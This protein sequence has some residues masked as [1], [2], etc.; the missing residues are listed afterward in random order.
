ME[1]FPLELEMDLAT[2][3][4]W[5]GCFCDFLWAI[6]QFD[7]YE[8]YADV[9]WIIMWII[10]FHFNVCCA[11]P[12]PEGIPTGTIIAGFTTA[13]GYSYEFAFQIE[14]QQAQGRVSVWE[15]LNCSTFCCPT[16]RC[17]CWE[18]GTWIQSKNIL[19]H[20]K[21][22]QWIGRLNL[23]PSVWWK[24]SVLFVLLIALLATGEQ[25]LRYRDDFEPASWLKSWSLKQ[26]LRF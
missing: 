25:S 18:K 11:G 8:V 14:A 26:H 1:A 17:V 6:Q 13:Q 20:L 10:L 19:Y 2:C 15:P 7:V 16:A 23:N 5:L 22:G 21:R 3:L 4:E 12:D 9:W 24:A